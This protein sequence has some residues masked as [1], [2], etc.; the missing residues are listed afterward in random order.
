MGRVFLFLQEHQLCGEQEATLFRRVSRG[1]L[2][3]DNVKALEQAPPLPT[4]CEGDHGIQMFLPF[5][6]RTRSSP[7]SPAQHRPPVPSRRCEGVSSS[8]TLFVLCLWLHP[9]CCSARRPRILLT[10]DQANQSIDLSRF[11]QLKPLLQL[12]VPVDTF[13]D[14]SK[15]QATTEATEHCQDWC[16]LMAPSRLSAHAAAL[17]ETTY[18]GKPSPTP[19]QSS[20][21]S[22]LSRSVRTTSR[23]G[24][25]GSGLWRYWRALR[26]NR[27]RVRPDARA[28]VYPGRYPQRKA[29]GADCK[30]RRS[31]TGDTAATTAAI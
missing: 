19:R 3:R 8:S 1:P 11:P 9:S 20:E 10:Q 13:R 31:C 6:R 28:L 23:V 2:D 16:P 18:R 26:W 24:Q 12:G 25:F 22:C 17:R 29:R 14:F 27:R 4:S 30:T 5:T 21:S 7:Q 15:E